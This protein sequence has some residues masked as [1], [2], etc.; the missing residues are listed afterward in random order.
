MAVTV[1]TALGL[2]G[3]LTLPLSAFIGAFLS[4]CIVVSVSVRFKASQSM[5][6]LLGVAM[7]S[8]FGAI[9]DAVITVV[10]DAAYMSAQFRVGDF[11]SSSYSRLIPSAV[12]IVAAVTAV[13]LFADRLDLLSLGDDVAQ[14]LGLNVSITRMLF[15]SAAALLAGCA[16]AMAGLLSFVGLI[17]PHAVKALRVT[18]G[19]VLLPL[20]ALFGGG[21]V[22]LC[23]L[24]ARTAFAPYEIPVGIIMSAVG[25]PVFLILLFRGR[26]GEML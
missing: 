25:V 4:V 16:V 20:C 5:I 15:L 17:V 1:S 3:S 9:S 8:L 14:S 18:E 6:I 13:T 22:T 2:W 21:F 26:G 24:I 23:D 11:S 7:N 10:P 19:K 12:L